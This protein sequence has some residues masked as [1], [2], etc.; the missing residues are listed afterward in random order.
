MKGPVL[1]AVIVAIILGD[2]DDAQPAADGSHEQAPGPSELLGAPPS[3]RARS[4]PARAPAARREP[5]STVPFLQTSTSPEP[6]GPN[7]RSPT[8]LPPPAAGDLLT[9]HTE[10]CCP[11]RRRGLSVGVENR[12]P[13]TTNSRCP[14]TVGIGDIGSRNAACAERGGRPD[15]HRPVPT[16]HN[17]ARHQADLRRS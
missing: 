10:Y 12:C 13:P 6:T 15:L 7:Y 9:A 5:T 4:P 3:G 1:L 11:Q 16:R 14:L 8:S 17:A 2:V